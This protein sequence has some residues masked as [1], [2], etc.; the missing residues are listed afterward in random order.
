MKRKKEKTEIIV[1][2]VVGTQALTTTLE[3]DQKTDQET[4]VK[5]ENTVRSMSQV[6]ETD[7]EKEKG[8]PEPLAQNI[9]EAKTNPAMEGGEVPA[10]RP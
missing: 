6:I 4:D 9:G 5:E 10:K 1:L 3:T 7:Q 2:G 8:A